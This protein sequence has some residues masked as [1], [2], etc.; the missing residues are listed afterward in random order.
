MEFVLAERTTQVLDAALSEAP[1]PAR[2]APSAQSAKLAARAR[3]ARTPK[4]TRNGHRPTTP[5]PEPASVRAR[6]RSKRS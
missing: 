2:P 3:K 5:R 4:P 1:Q 6:V